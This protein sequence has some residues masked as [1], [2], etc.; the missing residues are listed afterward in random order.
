[1]ATKPTCHPSKHMATK[2][3]C[4]PSKR[5]Y[6]KGLCAS[7]YKKWR[8]HSDPIFKEREKARLRKSVKKWREKKIKEDPDWNAARQREFRKKHPEKFNF[9]MARFYWRKLS[10]K[11]RKKLTGFGIGLVGAMMLLVAALFLNA[12]LDK[13]PL[14]AMLFFIIGAAAGWYGRG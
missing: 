1:M 12:I 11:D 7:C 4:H 13:N 3:T 6:A 5:Y 10:P 2:P 14:W 8:Y 9:I